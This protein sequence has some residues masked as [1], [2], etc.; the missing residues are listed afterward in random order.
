M[1][2][3]GRGKI[4]GGAQGIFRRAKVQDTEM[5]DMLFPNIKVQ[6]VYWVGQKFIWIFCDILWK[7]PKELFGQPHN[8]ENQSN[9]TC[10]F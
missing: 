9:F 6:A 10:R 1:I 4:R 3:G 7:N 8:T 2:W 5:K